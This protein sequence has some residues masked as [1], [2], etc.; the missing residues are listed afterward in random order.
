MLVFSI[1]NEEYALWQEYPSPR[2]GYAAGGRR[3]VGLHLQPGQGMKKRVLLMLCALILALTATA[4]FACAE[5]DPVSCA[6]ELSPEFLVGPGEV[7]VTITISNVTDGDL[8]DPVVLF[9]P[10]A[11]IISDFGNG[12]SATLKAGES[13]TW[14]GTYSVNEREL[15][16]GYIQYFA[17]YTVYQESGQATPRSQSIRATVS[18]ME[19]QVAIDVE[20][21]ITP[22]AAREGQEVQVKYAITNAGTVALENVTITENEDINSKAQTIPKLDPGAKAELTYKATMGK[23]DLTSSATVTYQGEGSS[24]KETYTVEEKTIPYA[25]TNL[26]ATLSSSAKGVVAGGSLTLSLELKNKG[27]ADLS[28]IRVTDAILGDVF[29]NQQVKAGETIT[30]EKEVTLTESCE[31][32]FTINAI[33]STGTEVSTASNALPVTAMNP[34]DALNLTLTAV[35]DRTEVYDDPAGVRFTLTITNDSRVDATD[36]KISHGYVDLYTFETIKAG[37]SRTMSR[38]TVLSTSGKFQFTATAKDPLENE[39]SFVSNE[40]QIAVYEPTPVPATPTPPPVPTAEPTFVPATWAPI[41]HESIGTVPKAI[42]SV[43]LPALIVA[44]VLLLA[45]LVLLAIAAKKRNDSKKASE[46]AYDHLE[47]TRRRDYVAANPDEL[48][49]AS[50]ATLS[51]NRPHDEPVPDMITK[52]TGDDWELP[53][54]GDGQP[55]EEDHQSYSSF[56]QGFYGEVGDDGFEPADTQNG[57]ETADAVAEDDQPDGYQPYDYQQPYQ[58]GHYGDS[59]GYAG[60]EQYAQDGYEAADAQTDGYQ[61]D[62]YQPYDYQQP[63]QEGRYGVSDGYAGQEQYAQDGYEAA[64]AQTDGYQADGYQ[65]YDYQQPYQEGRYGVSDGY[66]GQEQY[67][68][69]SYDAADAQKDGYQADSYQPYDYN[70]S[71]Q[72]GRYGEADGYAMYNDRP[73]TFG[74]DRMSDQQYGYQGQSNDYLPTYDGYEPLPDQPSAEEDVPHTKSRRSRK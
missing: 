58:D 5:E 40:M 45:S 37:E 23:K 8:Q 22:S 74:D 3:E 39:S 21:T 25:Q 60:Q 9:S 30:L 54:Y 72:E 43:L 44:G 15:D 29:T 31:Y 35:P 69:G 66:A 6:I 18:R 1:W 53:P 19:A 32:Q 24:K 67:A 36:V 28:D 41:Y 10:Q 71:Y 20:R 16:Q 49:A 70:Q 34:E 33:D 51:Q 57:Y 17:K 63:Y 48:A 68:Q 11:E 7:S 27:S 56:G 2:R 65:P 62:G 47:R 64:D 59:D 52:D 46:A 14:T 38:D 73:E 4:S 12:G 13:K 50:K 55:S 26:A 42:Q 61:A